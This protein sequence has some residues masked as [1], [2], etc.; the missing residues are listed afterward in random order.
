MKKGEC[1]Y[2]TRMKETNWPKDDLCDPP[3]P[4]QE[5]LNVL[6]DEILGEDW[7]VA[8]P[9][10]AEQ[11]NTAAMHDILNDLDCHNTW[12]AISVVINLIL[13]FISFL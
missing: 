6:I 2:L 7:Y 4:P 11:V 9:E 3:T 10:N 12:L 5:C 8:M 13:L 1:F